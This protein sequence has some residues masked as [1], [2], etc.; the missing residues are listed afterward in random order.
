MLTIYLTWAVRTGHSIQL[1]R[2]GIVQ[3][4]LMQEFER[5]HLFC[6][7]ITPSSAGL[8]PAK[9][10]VPDTMVLTIHSLGHVVSG[11]YP[12]Q[13]GTFF[14]FTRRCLIGHQWSSITWVSA[15]CL[16][17]SHKPNPTLLATNPRLR[18]FVPY[19]SPK[20]QSPM[21]SSICF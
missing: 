1:Y 11:W 4:Y 6:S 20:M 5:W 12:C 7:L 14:H 19:S 15:L 9:E 8:H 16:T 17:I 10:R 2:S 21:F 13:E 3:V 18:D